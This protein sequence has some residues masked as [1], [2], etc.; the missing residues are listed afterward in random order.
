MASNKKVIDALNEIKQGELTAVLTFM[1]HGDALKNMGLDALAKMYRKE[2][3][4][5]MGHSEKL[6]E[7]IHFL[8]GT[9]ATTP[10]KEP[11]VGRD[12]QEILKND[13]AMEKGQIER[14][15]RAIR[16]CL[17]EADPGSRVLCEQ[18]LVDEEKHY[19]EL[20]LM[21]ENLTKYG[22]GYLACVCGQ[23]VPMVPPSMQR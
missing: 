15:Q 14:V 20:T 18:I 7:R 4:E 8:G 5:E 22:V 12:L 21:V 6:A 16:L 11:K 19:S 2:A 9:P 3:V 1:A 23:G 17:E 13:A 10:L